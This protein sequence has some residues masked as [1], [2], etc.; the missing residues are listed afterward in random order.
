[1]TT[2]SS[3]STS[4]GPLRS[5]FDA[6][7]KAV[8]GAVLFGM[9]LMFTMEMWWIGEFTP[10]PRLLGILV[11]TFALNVALAR[12]SG[13]RDEAASIG[14]DVAQAVEA[15]AVGVLLSTAVLF[16][17]GRLDVAA[18]FES[19]LGTV[20]VQVLPLSLGAMIANVVFDPDKD[21]AGSSRDASSRTPLGELANDVAATF[22]GAAFVAFAIAP[23]DEISML[24]AGVDGANVLAIVALSVL[25]GYLIVFASGFDPS[26]HHPH[27]NGLFQEPFTESMLA[28]VVSLA[29]A[30]IMLYG[31]GQVAF[32][33]PPRLV[34]VQV[35]VLAVPA[36]IGGAAGRVVV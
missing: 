13:F 2:S 3:A 27:D 4:S 34:L 15:M 22:V 23:T 28:Y 32:G 6:I 20:I 11:V 17:L 18:S 29:A 33:D 7:A 16:A 21:R 36:S 31:F 35:L 24:A 14:S 12:L 19:I 26:H 30:T 1:M 9:P 10:R 25:A 5:E 8:G